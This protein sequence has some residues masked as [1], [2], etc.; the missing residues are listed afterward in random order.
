MK[1]SKAKV[2]HEVFCRPMA[3]HVIESAARL[4]P[5]QI[6]VVIGHQQEKVRDALASPRCEFAVQSEQLGTGHA[7]LVTE[8]AIRDEADSVLILCGDT[9]LILPETL[10]QLCR[11]HSA[12]DNDITLLT[13]TLSEPFGYGRILRDHRGGIEAIVEEKDADDDQRAITEVNAGIYCVRRSFLFT[14]LS[15]IGSDNS[16]GEMY[17]TDIVGIAVGEQR[18][19]QPFHVNNPVEVLGVNSRRELAAADCELQQRR[20]TAL[21]AAGV[22]ILNPQ[23]VRVEPAVTIAADTTLEQCLHISG[24]TTTIGENCHIEQGC[25]IRECSIG[26]GS[27]IGA[28]SFLSGVTL[29]AGSTIA[30]HTCKSA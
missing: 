3:A 8:P 2:L 21:M 6:L 27:T 11:C 25:V 20:N 17:L 7:V 10:E 18:R 26:A 13:T 22:S 24:S 4:D 15:R 1:S 29:P 14:A 30:A 12:E 9:P 28:G 16:Q 19:V 23:S 5:V